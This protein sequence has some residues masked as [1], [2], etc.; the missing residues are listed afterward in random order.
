MSA[1]SI[2]Q[3]VRWQD[4]RVQ[5]EVDVVFEIARKEGWEDCEIF[6]YGDMI[7]KPQE[8]IG[9]ELLPADLYE[10]SIPAEGISRILPILEAGVRIQ[11]VVIADDRRK[12]DRPIASTR[13]EVLSSIVKKAISIVS[14]AQ[15]GFN[16]ALSGLGKALVGLLRIA[17]VIALI[18]LAAY[19]II[20]LL[21]AMLILGLGIL[22][23][24]GTSVSYDPKLVILIDDG[25]G[26]LT[27]VSIFTWFE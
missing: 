11:G 10:G 8:I 19:L 26:D 7:T 12:T 23:S 3:Q 1:R 18:S 25:K 20:H 16:K 2:I 6:G 14:R 22:V 24:K 21:P 27:W 4:L 9:W 15:A 5:S 13:N 17:G